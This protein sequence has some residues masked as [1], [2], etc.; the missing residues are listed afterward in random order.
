MTERLEAYFNKKGGKV[1]LC[2][3]AFV[4]EVWQVISM[5]KDDGE[6]KLYDKMQD[7]AKAIY[8]SGTGGHTNEVVLKRRSYGGFTC[9][10]GK[11]VSRLGFDL[12]MV[13]MYGKDGIDPVY[14]PFQENCNLISIGN[15]GKTQIFEFLDGKVML[16]Y[17]EEINNIN[18]EQ[19]LS[20]VK[21]EV[22]QATFKEADIIGLGYWSFLRHFDE[23]IAK[24]YDNFVT[25]GNCKRLFF[26]FADIRKKEKHLLLN[27]LKKLAVLNKQVPITLSLNEH[28]ASLLFSYMG[29]PF[30]YNDISRA[31]ENINYIREQTGLDELVVHTPYFAAAATA[32]E[33]SAVVS[34]IYCEN[35]VITTGAG[36]NFNGGYLAASVRKGELNL[37]ERLLAGNAATGFYVQ[38]GYSPDTAELLQMCLSAMRNNV[39]TTCCN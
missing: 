19:L 4:D 23:L 18:W 12:T 29:R 3:D 5:R 1:T 22:L 20:T 8:D 25:T 28:E 6:Y 14:Q 15:P 27:T 7:F 39:S 32:T 35:P 11:L 2:I 26:D 33:G 16:A 21:W 38:N 30:V 34:Q 10:T 17:V 13:G 37:K 31:G 24:L 9:N 36:D